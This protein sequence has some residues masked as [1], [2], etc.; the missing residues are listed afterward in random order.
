MPAPAKNGSVGTWAMKTFSIATAFALVGTAAFAAGP[1]HADIAAA[2][3]LARREYSVSELNALAGL[4]ADVLR[5][6][7][8]H[9]MQA[10]TVV[11]LDEVTVKK[12]SSNLLKLL[13]GIPK[14]VVGQETVDRFPAV[15]V[16]VMLDSDTRGVR[17]RSDSDSRAV[18][19]YVTAGESLNYRVGEYVMV[20]KAGGAITMSKLRLPEA[21]VYTG[22]RTLD[23]TRKATQDTRAHNR[24]AGYEAGRVMTDKAMR[25][26]EAGHVR[27]SS[28]QLRR[29]ADEGMTPELAAELLNEI[30]PEVR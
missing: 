7:H 13:A 1:A 26:I 27:L 11:T 23:E 16:I 8:G 30:Q 18:S 5:R 22:S 2:P 25:E 17:T 12:P 20:G 9:E 28:S 21:E 24:F 3:S 19:F 14:A 4:N 6:M 15:Q 10:G 29:M